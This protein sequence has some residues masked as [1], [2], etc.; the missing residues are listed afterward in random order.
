[1]TEE[2][3]VRPSSVKEEIRAGRFNVT[4]PIA[5]L[6][7]DAKFRPLAV[8]ERNKL[9]EDG[10]KERYRYN[11]RWRCEVTFSAI[12]RMFGESITTRRR[13]LMFREAKLRFQMYN[14]MLACK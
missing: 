4:R 1:M 7:R 10:W 11:E 5:L 8:K 2:T 3:P 9:G 6:P 13:D 12:K 14:K